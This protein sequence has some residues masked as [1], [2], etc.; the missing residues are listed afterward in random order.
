MFAITRRAQFALLLLLAVTSAAGCAPIYVHAYAER[1]TAFNY[2]TYAWAPDAAV[3]T[4]DPRLDNNRFFAEQV[5]ASVDRELTARGFEKIASS[6]SELLIDFHVT[7]AQEVATT[8][9]KNFEHCVN[10][11]T[12]IYDAGTLVIDLVDTRSSRLVWRG[13]VEKLDPAID[14]QDWMEVTIDRAVT[15]IMRKLPAPIQHLS[16]R[17]SPVPAALQ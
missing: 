14:N 15:Q 1:G 3:A 16:D 8:S 2:Q 4:G 6:S 10:C 9:T 7:I 11:G 17:A 5:R 12:T 13:W